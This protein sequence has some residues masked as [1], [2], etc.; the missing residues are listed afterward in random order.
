MKKA[1]ALLLIL[2]SV[3]FTSANAEGKLKVSEKNLLIYSNDDNGY[4]YAKIEN[5][6]DIPVGVDS[7]DLVLFSDDDEIIRTDSYI[8]TVPS[9]VILQPGEYIYAKDFI[10][11]SALKNTTVGDYKFSVSTR[12]TANTYEKIPCEAEFSLAGVGSYD[13]YVYV[14]FTNTFDES[15]YGFYA[16]CALYDS[17]GSLVFVDG[18]SLSNVAVHPGS[19]VTIKFYIDND[20]MEH[21]LASN[22]VPTTVDAMVYYIYE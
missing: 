14:T 12:N 16:T 17:N 19:T 2:T 8:T 6:G 7:G 11:D 1:L 20:M 22:I 18:G 3:I 10:W 21:Y 4:F 5:T 9:Y 13:N 15:V